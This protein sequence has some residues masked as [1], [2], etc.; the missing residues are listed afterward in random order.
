MVVV[1]L[2]IV[3]LFIVFSQSF[4]VAQMSGEDG[5]HVF[6][7]WEETEHL[8]TAQTNRSQSMSSTQKGLT[9][10][11]TLKFFGWEAAAFIHS[12]TE[13]KQAKPSMHRT[14]RDTPTPKNF[15]D[16]KICHACIT[17]SF[18]CLIVYSSH[19]QNSTLRWLFAS[20]DTQFHFH[21][22]LSQHT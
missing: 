14:R 12:F 1:L 4:A 16:I 10:T 21:A 22:C 5:C 18:F 15:T 3:S 17:V 20:S 11:P 2:G 19:N 9:H 13:R 8:Q 7:P 6:G